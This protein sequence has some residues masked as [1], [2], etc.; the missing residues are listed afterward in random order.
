M[1]PFA[2]LLDYKIFRTADNIKLFWSSYKVSR[3][4]CP[5][6]T[7]PGASRQ[8]II[9]SNTKFHEHRRFMQSMQ[10]RLKIRYYLTENTMHLRYKDQPLDVVEEIT[11]YSANSMR[12]KQF[13]GEGGG[14]EC[15]L[16][17]VT[18]LVHTATIVL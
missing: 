13:V 4:F 1:D 9:V 11:A 12:D 18:R 10:T 6:L 15:R 14:R 3:Y 5:I 7:K 8:T 17:N 2:V 16:L